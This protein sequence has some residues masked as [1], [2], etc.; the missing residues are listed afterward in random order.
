MTPPAGPMRPLPAGLIALLLSLSPGLAAGGEKPVG[1]ESNKQRCA[2]LCRDQPCRDF[3]FRG[4]SPDSTH[5]G[6]SHMHCPGAQGEGKPRFTWH[7]RRIVPGKRKRR[8]K[9]VDISGKHFPN[10][11]RVQD[12]RTVELARTKVDKNIYEF[13]GH[14]GIT[15][16]AE[17]RTEKKVAWYLTVYHHGEE[18]FTYRGE[19]EE[20]YFNFVPSIYLSPNGQRIAVVLG[21]DAMVKVDSA[22][23]V[24]SINP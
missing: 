14:Q 24:F 6:Y 13:A 16:K 1:A 21:L 22:M 5:I 12:Y 20:I 17:L 10:W 23:V 2:R 3:V 7:L 4:F 19:F 9:P 8:T 18:R 11:Y 15:I